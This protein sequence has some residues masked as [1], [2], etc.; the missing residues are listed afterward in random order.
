MTYNEVPLVFSCKQARLIGIVTIPQSLQQQ[1][2][3]VIIVGGPQY[4]AGS[5]RQF[6]LLAR[7]LATQGIATMRFD[8]RGMGDSEG[9]ARPFTALNDD[10]RAAIDTLLSQVPSLDHVAL[11]GLCDA[12]SAAMMYGYQDQRVRQLIVLNPWV[13]TEVSG[14]RTRLTHYYTQRFLNRDFWH[15]L[16]SGQLQIM[17]ALREF[18]TSLKTITVHAVQRRGGESSTTAAPTTTP[19]PDAYLLAIHKGIMQFQGSIL[20][21]LSGQDLIAQEFISLTR[22]NKHW[23]RIIRHKKITIDTL[24][25]ANHTFSSQ[26]W[27]Q[28]VEILTA[29]F[30]TTGTIDFNN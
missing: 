22:N 18:L 7:M 14:H 10:I 8:V 1:T 9:A 30:L 26:Q 5:H 13:H 24:A 11:W 23:R 27:R 3:V 29:Q 17:V 25:E 21:I 2:G 19:S 28:K 12:A 6:T 15:K 20:I 16:I 4:R